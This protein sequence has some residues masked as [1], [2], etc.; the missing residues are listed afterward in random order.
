MADGAD[1]RDGDLVADVRAGNAASFAPLFERW[2]GPVLGA[3]QDLVGERAEAARVATDTFQSVWLHLDELADPDDFGAWV[4]LTSRTFARQRQA[5]RDPSV[6][7]PSGPLFDNEDELRRAVAKVLVR[8]QVPALRTTA[9]V[10]DPVPAAVG[11]A[12][13]SPPVRFEPP[14]VEPAGSEPARFEAA[15]AEAAPE[16]ASDRVHRYHWGPAEPSLGL[17]DRLRSF[18]LSPGTLVALAIVLVGSVIWLMSRDET[19]QIDG[20]RPAPLFAPAAP[21]TIDGAAARADSA[22]GAPVGG[23]GVASAS[24]PPDPASPAP[25][26]AAAAPDGSRK[27]KVATVVPRATTPAKR[28]T[29]APSAPATTATTVSVVPRTDSQP[30]TTPTVPPSSATTATTARTTTTAGSTGATTA[31]TTTTTRPASTT[32]AS[33][34]RTTTTA[35]S[36][37]ASTARTT[38]TRATTVSTTATS[39]PATTRATTTTASTTAT[40]ASTTASTRA[41]TTTIRATTASTA[42]T[43]QPA[44]TAATAGTSAPA[45]VA[46]PLAG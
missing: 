15:A 20:G 31:R 46:V 32:T 4:L 40:S 22:G 12:S 26:G 29:A 17:A 38:T 23:S 33:T 36:T 44:T 7:A 11:A 19:S 37:T 9:E 8:R 41:T 21:T 5:E 27:V 30:S 1:P 39:Q 24:V 6:A 35:G 43:S 13:A 2:F 34:A 25:T 14:A 10:P 16:L 3:A 28:A 42:A 45:L 18:R